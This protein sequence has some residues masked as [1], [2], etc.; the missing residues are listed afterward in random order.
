LTTGPAKPIY[1]DY[2][3]TTPVDPRVADA[4]APFLHQDFG[5]P[6]SAHAY[7]HRAREAIE[8][9]REQVARL[10]GVH[11][12]E[13]VFTASGSEAN[14]LALKGLV[15]AALS[16]SA[17]EEVHVVTSAIEHPAVIETCRFL[18]RLGCRVTTIPVDRYGVLDLDRLRAALARRTLLVSVMHANNEIGTMQPIAEIAELAHAHGAILHTDAAQTVGKIPVAVGALGADL[19]TVAGHK[20]YAPKGIGA[21]Y[22]REG[23]RLESLVHGGGH[24]AGRRAGTENVPHVVA[25]GTACEIAREAL[26]ASADR[27]ASLSEQLWRHLTASFGDGVVLNGHPSRRLPN[28]L[29]VSFLGQ[30][31]SEILARIPEVAASTGSACHEDGSVSSPVLEAMGV[32]PAVVRGAARFSIG[33]FT[34]EAEVDRAAGLLSS[35][36]ELTSPMR[37]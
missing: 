25:L 32:P 12:G 18:E 17:R 6:S 33:R 23:I 13:I 16:R 3:A 7:G 8:R 34:T 10:L 26:P 9:A 1:L 5:N 21:L 30:V 2:N 27:L 22:V 37:R 15:F 35:R 19:L 29:N 11:S 31:G 14:N 24:E 28:T 20:L 4:M 36:V